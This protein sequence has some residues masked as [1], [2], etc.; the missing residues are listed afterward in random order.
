MRKIL[1]ILALAVTTA[2]A[3]SAQAYTNL[4]STD[5]RAEPELG[6]GAVAESVLGVGVYNGW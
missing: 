1:P 6:T 4:G 2:F 3:T 5:Y